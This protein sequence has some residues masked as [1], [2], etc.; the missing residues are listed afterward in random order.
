MVTDFHDLMGAMRSYT[1]DYGLHGL[2]DLC[3]MVEASPPT[4]TGELVRVLLGDTEEPATVSLN[5]RS[6]VYLERYYLPLDG[7][8]RILDRRQRPYR[9][10][11]QL[12][13]D[14]DRKAATFRMRMWSVGSNGVD[15]GGRGDDLVMAMSWRV[16][17]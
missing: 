7:S 9:V 14:S 5:P 4:E 1:I 17:P 6:E 13:D 15:E 12:V 3:R 2:A 10:T 11:L 8:D 16:V